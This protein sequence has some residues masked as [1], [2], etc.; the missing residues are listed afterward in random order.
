VEPNANPDTPF[1]DCTSIVTDVTDVLM[2]IHE[3]R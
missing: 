1:E 3:P 2:S